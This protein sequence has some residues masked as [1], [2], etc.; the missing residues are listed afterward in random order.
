MTMTQSHPM[1]RASRADGLRNRLAVFEALM[2]LQPATLQEL[3]DST[4][5]PVSTVHRHL[6]ALIDVG[7]VY[8]IEGLR[9]RGTAQPDRFRVELN[10]AARRAAAA[11]ARML[12]SPAGGAAA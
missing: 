8:R 10:D 11:Q 1:I 4:K 12:R 7:E 3:A 5:L 6:S 9:G 2:D